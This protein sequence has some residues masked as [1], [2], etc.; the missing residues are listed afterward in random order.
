MKATLLITAA[1]CSLLSAS[2][3]KGT[4][5]VEKEE[6]TETAMEKK[7]MLLNEGYTAGVIIHSTEEGDCEW[8]I[9]LEDGRH[10][11]SISMQDEFKENGAKVFFKF[12]PQRRMSRCTK[13]N[14]IAITE[15]TKGN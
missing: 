7:E 2:S 11:E 15:M 1:L 13:A 5:G 3:C 14:P 4:Q 9:K 12:I 10:F 8:T 6:L